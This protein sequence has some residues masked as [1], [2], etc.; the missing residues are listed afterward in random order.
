MRVTS[1]PNVNDM[2][3]RILYLDNNPHVY[4]VNG[5]IGEEEERTFIR[6]D[7]DGFLNWVNNA[8]EH[9]ITPF[10]ATCAG[11]KPTLHFDDHGMT[12]V[13]FGV[14][15]RIQYLPQTGE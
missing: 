4:F 1:E 13:H 12:I 3:Q 14:V 11:V 9:K 8:G 10:T 15:M 7:I 2:I 6:F 5:G